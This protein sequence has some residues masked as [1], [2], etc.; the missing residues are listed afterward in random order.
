M[1]NPWQPKCFFNVCFWRGQQDKCDNA[2]TILRQHLVDE[3]QPQTNVR[4]RPLFLGLSPSL[5][6]V[7]SLYFFVYIYPSLSFPFSRSLRLAASLSLWL[8]VC[9]SGSLSPSISV[10]SFVCLSVS[11]G[12]A[13]SL[14]SLLSTKQQVLETRKLKVL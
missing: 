9:L 1:A 12:F 4:G 7:S 2:L 13:P 3:N 11:L 14:V 10:C 8:S 6:L 5:S